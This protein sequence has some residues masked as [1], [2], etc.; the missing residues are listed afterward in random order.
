MSEN[1]S[2][3]ELLAG[4]GQADITPAQ[5]I[6]IAGDIGRYRPVEE[7]RDRLQAKALVLRGGGKTSCLLSLDV[8]GVMRRYSTELR[9]RIADRLDTSPDAVIVHALQSHSAPVVGHHAIGDDCTLIPADLPWLRGGD[10]RYVEPFFNGVM[11]AVAGARASLQP[12]TVKAGR[13]ADGRVAFNRRFVM[14]DGT[15]KT[16]PPKCDPEILHCEGPTDPEVGVA[17]FE[18]ASGKAVAAILHHTCHPTHGYPQRWIS[19][20]WPGSWSQGTRGLLGE[21]CVP[22]VVNGACGNV[23]HANHLDPTQE[24]TIEAMGAKLTETTGRILS[25]LRRVEVSPLGWSSRM[26]R[27]PLRTL[28]AEEVAAA[29]KMLDEHPQP[30]WTDAEKTN[31]SWD[32]V[33]AAATLDLARRQEQQPW[34]D[35]EIQ[36]LRLGELA[37]AAW[38]GEPFVEA[39]LAVKKGSPAAYTFV[40]HFCNDSAGYI[41]TRRAFAGGGYETRTANWSQLAPEAL[42]TIEA[43]TLEMLQ[44]LC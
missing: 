16:H 30:V 43:A 35:C 20:D 37:V 21:Q 5:G 29:R 25:E 13:R 44:E 17:V 27:I 22:L 28:S 11:E 41:P 10:D 8:T 34:Y 26:L 6:Q 36:V 4:A 7:I 40:A 38:P 33:Y 15:V 14:R 31:V 32:W 19:A 24:D 23:H 9:R 1:A 2:G 12:V 42:E 3:G 18:G 39:Q